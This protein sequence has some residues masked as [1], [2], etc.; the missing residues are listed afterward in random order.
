[1]YIKFKVNS[2]YIIF[3]ADNAI[4]TYHR[5]RSE[6]SLFIDKQY[7]SVSESEAKRLEKILLKGTSNEGS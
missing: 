5:G 2:G 6:Y 1:M 4:L 3:N 7:F